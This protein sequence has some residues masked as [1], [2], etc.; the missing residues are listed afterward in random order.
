MVVNGPRQA[1]KTTLLR[2]QIHPEIGGT[3]VSLDDEAELA[4]CLND[5]ITFL[6]RPRPV[7]IDEFQRAVDRLLLAIKRIVDYEDLEG[8]FLL[9]G[10]TRFLTVPTISE[11]LAGRVHI[12]D[13]WPFSQGEALELG[14][15]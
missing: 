10:S 9:T 14:P 3:F 15:N 4:A 1:G 13:L 12:V 11:S 6:D 8:Q 2:R 5:P 7:I